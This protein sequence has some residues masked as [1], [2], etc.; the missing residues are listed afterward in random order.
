M[1][2]GLAEPHAWPFS[3]Q[4]GGG[5]EEALRP[6]DMLLRRA[7][8]A[9]E[10]RPEDDRLVAVLRDRLR[11]EIEDGEVMDGVVRDE[12]EVA[13]RVADRDADRFLPDAS[14]AMPDG[15]RR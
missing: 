10:R 9:G 4:R 8:L 13:A 15:L 12:R 7:L 11:L 14:G 2:S 3:D 1:W 6:E 5:V